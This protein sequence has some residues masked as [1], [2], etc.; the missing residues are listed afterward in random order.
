[1][2]AV[3][4]HTEV[5]AFVEAFAAGWRAPGSAAGLVENFRPLLQEDVR[6]LQPQIPPLVGL[7]EFRSGFA[8]PLFALMPDL[9][10]EV[11]DWAAR[12]DSVYIVIRLRGTLAGKPFQFR[13]CDRITLRDGR[14]AVRE[15]FMDPSPMVAAALT[16]PRAWPLFVR[17]QAR[18]IQRRLRKGRRT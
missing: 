9:H 5:E 12:G 7:D 11:E 6:L 13:S 18:T 3:A 4:Q 1:M 17:I 16:R 10:G 14:I 8:D 15:A 2:S